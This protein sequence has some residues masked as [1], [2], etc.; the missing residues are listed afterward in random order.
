M[1]GK[2]FGCTDPCGSEVSL[3]CHPPVAHRATEKRLY[4]PLH[5]Q[6][7]PGSN[8]RL[9]G[10]YSFVTAGN[11]KHHV[12]DKT[13]ERFVFYKLLVDLSVVLQKVLHDFPQ[14]LIVGHPCSVRCILPCILVSSVCGD[15][16]GNIVSNAL[17]DAVGVG[18]ES[19]K[20]FIERLNDVAKVIQL[21]VAL[22]ATCLCWNGL[23]LS[24]LI[25]QER[26]SMPP[27]S[28]HGSCPCQSL[29]ESPWKD[30]LPVELATWAL[31][32]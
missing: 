4:R 10:C 16:R 28:Q 19:S 24:I 31:A 3:K 11:G 27:F 32:D 22:S 12:S 20:M 23:D 8:A 18:K 26:S 2:P 15:L 29:Q 13:S 9:I 14:C 1:R 17:C 25:C 7:N 30:P 5:S 21:W 6:F